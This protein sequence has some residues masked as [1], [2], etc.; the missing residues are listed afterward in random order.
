MPFAEMGKIIS[1]KI[2]KGTSLGRENQEFC[3]GHVK[4]EPP[5]KFLDEAVNDAMVYESLEL[6]IAAWTQN[7]I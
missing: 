5:V 6:R 1:G 4:L 3:F 2:S 7:T